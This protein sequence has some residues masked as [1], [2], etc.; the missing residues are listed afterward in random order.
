MYFTNIFNSTEIL[1][2]ILILKIH[3]KTFKINNIS[4]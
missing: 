3:F 4:K 1:F 2:K